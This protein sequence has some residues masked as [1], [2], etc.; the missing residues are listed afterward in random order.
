MKSAVKITLAFLLFG[1][2]LGIGSV[3]I[4]NAD[5]IIP[6]NQPGSSNDPI[7]TKSYVD[8]SV[9]AIVQNELSKQSVDENKI[10]QLVTDALRTQGSGGEGMTVIGLKAGQVLY[11]GAGTE[12]I[13]RNGNA[14]AYSTDGNGIPDLT[15][16]KDI[17][18]GST[19][20]N[21]HLLLF[22]KD[23]GRGIKPAKGTKGTVYVMVRGR[24][25]WANEDGT[26]V[27]P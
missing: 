20:A 24:Y 23:G 18:N 4:S 19:I 27:K 26:E 6:D 15:A 13:V 5:G 11:A 17:A 8:E 16:G 10:K 7:V 25:L 14:V 21:N 12:F 3:F 9:R 1:S 2:G 22:P